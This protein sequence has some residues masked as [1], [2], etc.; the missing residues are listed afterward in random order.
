MI[1]E[2]L[3][4]SIWWFCEVTASVW[5]LWKHVWTFYVTLGWF[6]IICFTQWGKK[7]FNSENW[8]WFVVKGCQGGCHWFVYGRFPQTVEKSLF[9]SLVLMLWW[10]S[11]KGNFKFK[12]LKIAW[13]ISVC[14][15]GVKPS[16]GKPRHSIAKQ[17]SLKS[18]SVAYLCWSPSTQ[19]Y[20]RPS[21]YE[22][23]DAW[24]H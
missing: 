21:V 1:K 19:C 12:T 23:V 16:D 7:C 6:H 14:C 20:R 8:C 2:C 11:I 18:K 3:R 13:Y 9:F 17:K 24:C 22:R 4:I 15:A 10:S 5:A